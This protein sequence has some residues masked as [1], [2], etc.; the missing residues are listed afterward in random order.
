M[1]AWYISKASLHCNKLNMLTCNSVTLQGAGWCRS[2][3]CTY[4]TGSRMAMGRMGHSSTSC[5][6]VSPAH[7]WSRKFYSCTAERT[8]E[9]ASALFCQLSERPPPPLPPA[10]G[11]RCPVHGPHAAGRMAK[12]ANTI[13]TSCQAASTHKGRALHN[14]S[15]AFWLS[16]VMM[17]ELACYL[18][19]QQPLCSESLNYDEQAADRAQHL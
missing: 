10:H 5:W 16:M 19:M 17:Q 8:A 12:H 6:S 13:H 1:H 2:S 18:C 4:R 9:H 15:G 11:P 3:M 14:S 7:T